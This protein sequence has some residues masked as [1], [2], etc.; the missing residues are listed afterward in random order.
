MALERIR[1]SQKQSKVEKQIDKEEFVQTKDSKKR[2]TVYLSTSVAKS[3]KKLAVEKDE[4]VSML[5]EQA[6]RKTYNI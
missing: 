6:T 5:L 4:S 1:K 3:L 2:L